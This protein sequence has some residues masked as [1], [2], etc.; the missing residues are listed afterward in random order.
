MA[1]FA[2]CPGRAVADLLDFTKK[3]HCI[4]YDKATKSLFV[5]EDD[6]FNLDSSKLQNLLDRLCD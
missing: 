1:T 5:S 6:R 4:L 3:A 2:V